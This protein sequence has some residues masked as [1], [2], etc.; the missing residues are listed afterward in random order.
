MAT[1]RP[2]RKHPPKAVEFHFDEKMP[3]Q[4]AIRRSRP[5]RGASM[6]AA[7]IA[8][9]NVLC[10]RHGASDADIRRLSPNARKILFRI[11]VDPADRDHVWR[12]DAVSAL[13]ALGTRE[14]TMLLTG[15]ATDATEDAV[16]ISRAL[17]GLAKLGGEAAA[18]IIARSIEHRDE[19]VRTAALKALMKLDHPSAIPALTRAAKVHRSPV[20]RAR[21]ERRL[22]ELGAL[23]KAPRRIATRNKGE[24]VS[25]TRSR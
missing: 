2:T 16:I 5:L 3:R 12:R 22:A 15:L 10:R 23:V 19:F 17:N 21:A 13:A 14:A 6:A 20:L 8:V 1:K 24:L 18:G 7:R 9:E 11:V 4:P 25:D